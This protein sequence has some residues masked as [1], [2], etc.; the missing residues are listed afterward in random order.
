M[1]LGL[2][3]PKYLIKIAWRTTFFMKP[4]DLYHNW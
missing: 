4:F 1:H 3:R 2:L